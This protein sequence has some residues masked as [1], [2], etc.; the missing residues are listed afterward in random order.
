MRVS[1]KTHNDGTVALDLDAEAARAVF[2]SVIFAA[3]FHQ[4]FAMLAKVAEE[5]LRGEKRNAGERD[6][7]CQ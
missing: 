3:K 7:V 2:A 5:G 1:F 6:A 4:N